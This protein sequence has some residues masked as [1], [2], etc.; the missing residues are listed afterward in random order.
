M[1]EFYTKSKAETGIKL[2]LYRPDG[3]KSDHWLLIKGIDS[4]TFQKEDFKARRQRSNIEIQANAI[5]D[6]AEKENFLFEQ[7]QEQ[8][9]GII[10]A[11][12]ADWSFDKGEDF[13]P[14]AK[15]NFVFNKKNVRE[16]LKNAPQIREQIN[17]FSARRSLF[18]GNGSGSSSDSQE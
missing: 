2:P 10:A 5:K 13:D 16:F 18:F 11:L 12:V 8:E 4:I 3:T 15:P 1:E 17:Q 7:I 14:E 6:P 9:V